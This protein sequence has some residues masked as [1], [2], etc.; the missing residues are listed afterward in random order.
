MA[1]P[2][3]KSAYAASRMH[4]IAPSEKDAG[5]AARFFSFSALNGE[6][7]AQPDEVSPESGKWARV[8]Y[9]P[10]STS[11][12]QFGALNCKV[13]RASCVRPS[14]RQSHFVIRHCPDPHDATVRFDFGMTD[15]AADARASEPELR[16]EVAA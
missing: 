8:R 12:N 16:R 7:V 11:S 4:W 9:S 14:V 13:R 2:E 3:I 15:F 6:K 10:S 1:C 5:N